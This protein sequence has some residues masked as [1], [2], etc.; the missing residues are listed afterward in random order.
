MGKMVEKQQPG[1]AGGFADAFKKRSEEQQVKFERLPKDATEVDLY[2]LCAPFGAICPQGVK[3][4]KTPD[5][6]CRG[7]GW[8]DFMNEDDARNAV[9]NLNEF[10]G[11]E[12]KTFANRSKARPSIAVKPKGL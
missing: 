7:T 12:V 2:G 9:Q 10:C 4:A 5:G 1:A 6:V 3:V 11:L 8:V